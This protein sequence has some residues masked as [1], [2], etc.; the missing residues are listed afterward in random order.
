MS[1]N[2]KRAKR[3]KEKDII[4]R[5]ENCFVLLKDVNRNTKLAR[6]VLFVHLLFGNW[7]NILIWVPEIAANHLFVEHLNQ[8]HLR[9][10]LELWLHISLFAT[11][12]DGCTYDIRVSVSNFLVFIRKIL[13]FNQF[14]Y[15]SRL[16]TLVALC[17]HFLYY[18]QLVAL[19]F[20]IVYNNFGIFM[21]NDFL[22]QQRKKGERQC[23]KKLQIGIGKYSILQICWNREK[24]RGWKR[25]TETRTQNKVTFYNTN[26]KTERKMII[27]S[28]FHCD[29]WFERQENCILIKDNSSK[30]ECEKSNI[31]GNC[32]LI[33]N[34]YFC[35]I[36]HPFGCTVFWSA[37]AF[38]VFHLMLFFFLCGFLCS[39]LRFFL[40]GWS[41]GCLR[42]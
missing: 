23:M 7:T 2:K 5:F 35:W 27:Y 28:K 16:Y 36:F 42:L 32:N 24:E 34:S 25:N 15:F 26:K 11:T 3:L 38:L 13:I 21:A 41:L 20:L 4:K 30:W 12:F 39:F 19:F 1:R 8:R 17:I 18:F 22:N 31:Y 6:N 29:I 10:P 33:Y 40:F 9:L 14:F 37:K